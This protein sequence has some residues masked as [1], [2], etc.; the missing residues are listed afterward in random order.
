MRSLDPMNRSILSLVAVG[1]VLAAT[2]GQAAAVPP[3]TQPGADQIWLQCAVTSQ[4]MSSNCQYYSGITDEKERLRAGTI[5]GY[6]DAHPV[7]IPGGAV[8]AAASVFV[9][10][11]VT[12]RP[13]HLGYA[14]TAPEGASKPPSGPDVDD[15]VWIHSPFEHWAAGFTPDRVNYSGTS[16]EAKV[17]C[18]VSDSGALMDC[19]LEH[20]TPQGW[21]FGD[22]AMK[23]LTHAQMKPQGARGEPVADRPFAVTIKFEPDGK[24]EK[25]IIDGTERMCKF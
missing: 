14:V 5:L 13:D 11:T 2:S 18:K 19:W 7:P 3:D 10:L 9:R 1:S 15:P 12:E 17:L 22:A 24:V 25:C 23:L 4:Q 8:G 20:E 16:G 21:G 6:L